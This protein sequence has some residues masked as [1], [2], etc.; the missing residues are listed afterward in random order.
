MHST[1]L[2][3]CI[4]NFR[5]LVKFLHVK[6]D[7]AVSVHAKHNPTPSIHLSTTPLQGRL[8][9]Y[10]MLIRFLAL[11]KLTLRCY[12]I[13]FYQSVESWKVWASL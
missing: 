10:C 8:P 1:H 6:R 4:F 13:D 9:H 11:F 3:T 7:M 2:K 12:L 5:E